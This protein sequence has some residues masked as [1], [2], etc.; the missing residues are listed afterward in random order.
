MFEDSVHRRSLTRRHALRMGAAAAATGL[1]TPRAATAA[2]CRIPTFEVGLGDAAGWRTFDV[3]RAP[4]RF[5]MLGLRWASAGDDVRAE[6]RARPRDGG[7]TPWTRLHRLG[8]HGPDSGRGLEGTEPCWTDTADFFQVRVRGRA[9]GLR[10]RFVRAKPT[11]RLSRR[12]AARVGRA[13]ARPASSAQAGAPPIIARAAWGG[14]G[15]PPRTAPSLGTVQLAFVHHTVTANDYAPEDSAAIVLGIC[16]YHRNS[17]G[18]ND[19]GYNFLVDKY[20]QIFEGRAGGIDQPVI[21]AQAQGY[22]S[23]STGIA[24][25]GDYTGGPPPSQALDALARL[26]GW[27]L[28]LHGVPVTGT[29][30]LTSRGG[31]ENRYPSGTAVTLQRVSGHRDGD[32]T[33]CPGDGLYAQLPALRQR[34][35]AYATPVSAVSIRVARSSVRYPS[36]LALSGSV[37]FGDGASADRAPVQIQFQAAGAAWQVLATAT[38]DAAGAWSASVDTSTSGAVRAVFPGDAS[39]PPMESAPLN[40]KVLPKLTCKLGAKRVAT[41]S[42]V[43]VTGALGPTWPRR[44]VLVFE[45]RVRGRW[46]RVQRKRI[47]VRGGGFSSTVRPKQGGLHRVRIIAPGVT[48]TRTLRASG[49]TGGATAG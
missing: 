43:S 37:R 25:L 12:A 24:V 10:V 49:V 9:R 5:D 19:L 33:S 36:P 28:S 39:H 26:I 6:I 47:N 44:V 42:A 18:W 30:T 35:A 48:K 3:M 31:S 13:S 22:N 29:V 20:G 34:A 15:C 40:V 17:N 4:R 21:G 38:A 45:R 11:A 16:R 27:K 23:D 14:D 46:V 32:R 1:L 2:S 8:D 7:W 41:G